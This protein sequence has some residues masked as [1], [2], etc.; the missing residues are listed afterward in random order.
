[1]MTHGLDQT[2]PDFPD[3]RELLAASQSSVLLHVQ[4]VLQAGVYETT[5]KGSKPQELTTFDASIPTSGMAVIVTISTRVTSTWHNN[6]TP[7]HPDY[8]GLGFS[9]RSLADMSALAMMGPW[10][11]NLQ[12]GYE[13]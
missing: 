11:L 8:P 12:V 5:P 9:E 10:N 13:G 4:Y 6:Q 1:M 7:P 3:F 2:T